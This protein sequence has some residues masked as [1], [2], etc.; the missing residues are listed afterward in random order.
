MNVDISVVIPVHDRPIPL[1]YTLESLSRAIQDLKVEIIIVDDGSKKPISEDL[2]DY[3][4]LPLT[5]IRQQNKGSIS[6]RMTGF[7]KSL[8]KYIL[9]LD[10]DDLVH[11]KKLVTQIKKMDLNNA[12]VS[13]TDIASTKLEGAYEYLKINLIY[14]VLWVY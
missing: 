3:L 9:F 1:K 11:P 5:F 2:G 14:N 7:K 10:S 13:Y 6:A 8:G 4:H 12:D